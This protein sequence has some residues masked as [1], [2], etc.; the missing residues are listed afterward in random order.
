MPF[1]ASYASAGAISAKMSRFSRV[2]SFSR[3]DVLVSSNKRY[4]ERFE[5]LLSDAFQAPGVN[6]LQYPQI[7]ILVI[8]PEVGGGLPDAMAS[9]ISFSVTTIGSVHWIHAVSIQ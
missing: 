2:A 4:R 6:F 9:L 7:V 3:C 5:I 8:G 1:P